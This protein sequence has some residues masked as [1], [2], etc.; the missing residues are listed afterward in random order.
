MGHLPRD[1]FVTSLNYQRV[2]N[3]FMSNRLWEGMRIY[4]WVGTI[5]VITAIIAGLGF[6]KYSFDWWRQVDLQSTS[7]LAAV[8]NYFSN[9]FQEGYNLFVLGGLKYVVLILMEV[10]IFHFVR[11]TLEVITNKSVDHSF[12]TFLGAQ[13]RMIKVAM[14]SYF[15][16]SVWSIIANIA[17]GLVGLS[18]LSSVIAVLIQ[19]FFL[20]FA[21]VDNYNEVYHMTLKQSFRYAKVYFGVSLAIGLGVYAL[22]IIPVFGT[23]LGPLTGA[24]V[25]AITMH[26]LSSKDYKMHAVMMSTDP[27]NSIKSW[28]KFWKY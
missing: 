12:K 11:R 23:I 24:I 7:S 8:G 3:F 16:E 21:I 27:S 15:L 2:Y 18:V 20:G 17:L 4:K 22:M 10:V 1:F 5:L 13:V 26:E 25:A 28:L 6:F 14:L 9:V 19:C